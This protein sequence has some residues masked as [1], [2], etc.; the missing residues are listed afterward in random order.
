FRAE[1]VIEAHL[2]GG[3]SFSFS[4]SF[5]VGRRLLPQDLLGGQSQ[6]LR[7]RLRWHRLGGGRHGYGGN[8]PDRWW[9]RRCRRRP[10]GWLPRRHS[11]IVIG[12]NLPNGRE[13]FVHRGLFGRGLVHQG[14][15]ECRKTRR[16]PSGLDS[17]NRTLDGPLSIWESRTIPELCLSQGI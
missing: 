11:R 7:L 6:R 4:F 16:T 12:D 1:N 15:L 8:R 13:N 5:G 2:G 14:L 17:S 3:F 9:R 10:C